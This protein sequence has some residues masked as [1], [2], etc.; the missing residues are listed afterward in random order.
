MQTFLFLR[1]NL[2]MYKSRYIKERVYPIHEEISI[3]IRFKNRGSLRIGFDV[4]NSVMIT[5]KPGYEPVVQSK[6]PG[7]SSYN[8]KVCRSSNPEMSPD[9]F[10][11]AFRWESALEYLSKIRISVK[12]KILKDHWKL[13]IEY[14]NYWELISINSICVRASSSESL[15][16]PEHRCM[17]TTNAT[18]KRRRISTRKRKRLTE[19]EEFLIFAKKRKE[20]MIPPP[21]AIK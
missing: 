19:A 8:W 15:P 9:L 20:K 17:T 5:L 1:K 7:W 21:K 10:Q 16:R 14:G 13:K 4:T 6:T 18:T 12:R 2:K 3:S 11:T